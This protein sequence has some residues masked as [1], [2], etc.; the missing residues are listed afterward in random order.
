VEWLNNRETKNTRKLHSAARM[1]TDLTMWQKSFLRC[2]A[3]YHELPT[4]L[5][6]LALRSFNSSP[7]FQFPRKLAIC[8]STALCSLLLEVGP[9]CGAAGIEREFISHQFIVVRWHRHPRRKRV[10]C[11]SKSISR[12]SDAH[13]GALFEPLNR[14]QSEKS[15]CHVDN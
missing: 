6:Q 8:G 14:Q 1:P 2:L 4:A 7:N 13:D 9:S 12:Y 3:R 11:A 10:F 15:L 5:I